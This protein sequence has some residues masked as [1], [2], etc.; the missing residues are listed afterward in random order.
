MADIN[1]APRRL[2]R[3]SVIDLV[4][5]GT[6]YTVKNFNGVAMITPGGYTP[7]R[8]TDRG[9]PQPPLLGDGNYTE[10][11]LELIA[12][13]KITG[14]AWALL[15]DQV[16]ATDAN[17]V[18]IFT[19]TISIPTPQSPSTGERWTDAACFMDMPGGVQFRGGGPGL[20][21]LTIRGGS[22]TVN[23]AWAAY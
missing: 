4:I 16:N 10:F 2:N 15:A 18:K 19:L 14:Q 22:S 8:Y 1:T 20:D 3:L 21:T 7:V 23:P 5:A 12:C 6:T 11:E 17:L 9:I 13:S